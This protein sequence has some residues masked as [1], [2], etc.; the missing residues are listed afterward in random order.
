LADYPGFENASFLRQ[1]IA[2]ILAFYEPHAYD[3]AGG[4]FHHFLDDGSIYDKDT[5]HLVSSARFVFNYANAFMHTGI[6]FGNAKAI[7]S[8]MDVQ[9][10]MDMRLSCLPP[11]LPVALIL[12]APKI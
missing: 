8:R 5:R 9:W 2:D 3:P 1:H 11:P 7:K 10:L 4:F 6:I 12:P